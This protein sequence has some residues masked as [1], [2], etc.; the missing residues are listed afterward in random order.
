MEETG[1]QA[2]DD[3]RGSDGLGSE[4]GRGG[5]IRDGNGAHGTGPVG[6]GARRR[7]ELVGKGKTTDFWDCSASLNTIIDPLST[8]LP[9]PHH[10]RS[11]TVRHLG[12]DQKYPPSRRTVLQPRQ[13]S[14]RGDE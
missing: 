10:R 14:G 5:K 6:D 11:I 12:S 3:G 9:P 7:K 1:R 8:K 4:G 13:K 2:R